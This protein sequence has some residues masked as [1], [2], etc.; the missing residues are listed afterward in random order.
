MLRASSHSSWLIGWSPTSTTAH[1]QDTAPPPRRFQSIT[2]ACSR[3][4]SLQ[5]IYLP[6]LPPYLISIVLGVGCSRGLGLQAHPY[7]IVIKPTLEAEKSVKMETYCGV[8]GS[9]T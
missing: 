5:H 7:D 2:S 3:Q 9:C 4:D 1:H 6:H 8:E